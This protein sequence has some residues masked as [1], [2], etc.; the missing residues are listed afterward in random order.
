M[1]SFILYLQWHRILGY[2]FYEQFLSAIGF[3]L[4]LIPYVT[5]K[6]VLY[7]PQDQWNQ[8]WCPNRVFHSK[9]LFL[10]SIVQ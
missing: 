3:P 1:F 10:L 7:A 9:Y 8:I 4:L 6:S 2:A 5:P